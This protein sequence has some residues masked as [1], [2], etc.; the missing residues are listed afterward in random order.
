L[1]VRFLENHH[2]FTPTSINRRQKEKQKN[3]EA[4]KAKIM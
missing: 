1:Q 4:I 3:L 2:Y